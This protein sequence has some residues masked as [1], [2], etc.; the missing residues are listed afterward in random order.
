MRVYFVSEILGNNFFQNYLKKVIL[1]A[2]IFLSISSLV[3]LILSSLNVSKNL[4]NLI[5][6][7]IFGIFFIVVWAFFL[8]FDS[9]QR[10]SICQLIV[11]LLR[12]NKG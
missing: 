5:V 7:N 6:L 2:V 1:P 12:K 8:L 4:L 9:Q 11:K 3:F 10:E